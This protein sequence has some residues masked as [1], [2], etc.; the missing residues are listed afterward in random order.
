[1]SIAFAEGTAPLTLEGIGHHAS[2][3]GEP[4][5]LTERRIK[6]MK[7]YVETPMPGRRDE[8]WRRVEFGDLDLNAAT[9]RGV[10]SEPMAVLSM[11]SNEA[12]AKNVFWDAP[13]DAIKE[14]PELME[15]YWNTEVYA[16]GATGSTASG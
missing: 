7:H 6:A 16:A 2:K 9:V 12:R 14:R 13:E 5:F 1:M 15:K 3:T 8:I 11:L 10:L 4:A